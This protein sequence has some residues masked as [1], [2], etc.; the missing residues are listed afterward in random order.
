VERA[1]VE[2]LTRWLDWA[3]AKSKDTLPKAA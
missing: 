1:D 2:A 3:F